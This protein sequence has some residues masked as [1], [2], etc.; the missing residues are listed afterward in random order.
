MKSLRWKIN[1]CLSFFEGGGDRFFPFSLLS[2]S[3]HSGDFCVNGWFPDCLGPWLLLLGGHRALPA[4]TIS[5]SPHASMIYPHS[6]S[7]VETIPVV[8]YTSSPL[9]SCLWVLWKRVSHLRFK[10]F[11]LRSKTKLN[12]NRTVFFS[13]RYANFFSRFLSLRFTFLP[14]FSSLFTINFV[15][16]FREFFSL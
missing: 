10:F 2:F 7:F 5:S 13:L 8:C 3:I 11:S 6:P 12:K 4:P 9:C 16:S 15:A 14:R 1:N